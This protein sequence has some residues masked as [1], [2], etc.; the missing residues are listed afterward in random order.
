MAISIT[1]REL[2]DLKYVI[3]F[4]M[5]QDHVLLLKRKKDPWTNKW[6]GAGGKIEKGET[7]LH[8]L[9]R[10]FLEETGIVLTKSKTRF[11]GIVTWEINGKQSNI[12][13]YAFLSFLSNKQTT[14]D[15]ERTTEEGILAWKT[16]DW[17]YDKENKEIAD[18]I[19]YFL[20]LMMKANKPHGYHCIFQDT[21]LQ[22]VQKVPY[23]NSSLLPRR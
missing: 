9:Y 1:A 14:W 20:P 8:A 23:S 6:N 11:A 4:P 12:G 13:M 3:G 18:N 22:E 15:Q 2:L 21:I 5:K 17:A 16:L 10:E 19:P 7:P